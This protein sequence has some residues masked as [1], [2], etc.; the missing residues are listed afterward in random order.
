MSG[1]RFFA[2]VGVSIAAFAVNADAVSAHTVLDRLIVA[3]QP[4]S[5]LKTD[6]VFG[7]VSI[8]RLKEVRVPAADIS[9]RDDL[10]AISMDGS[11]ACQTSGQALFPG[12]ATASLTARPEIDLASCEIG[13]VSIELGEFGGTFALAIQQ[14]SGQIEAALTEEVRSGLIDACEALSVAAGVEP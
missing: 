10:L 3:E 6:T 7:T 11:L 12:D 2:G 1:F 14:F 5:G 4:C 13:D 8:D 9:L